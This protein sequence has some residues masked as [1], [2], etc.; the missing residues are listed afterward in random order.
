MAE[1]RRAGA[2]MPTWQT[3]VVDTLRKARRPDVDP[4]SAL[5]IQYALT[6]V[7]TRIDLLLVDESRFARGHHLQAARTAYANLLEEACRLAEIDDLPEDNSSLRRMM[8]EA[9]LRSRGWSW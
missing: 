9:E 8:A 6:R 5:Q 7:E 1:R 2:P 3:W 4:F